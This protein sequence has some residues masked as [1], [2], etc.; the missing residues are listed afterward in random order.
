L[1]LPQRPFAF[2]FQPSITTILH[3]TVLKYNNESQNAKAK[4][5]SSSESNR[6]IVKD[7]YK[8][9]EITFQI[10]YRDLWKEDK[11]TFLAVLATDFD[12]NFDQSELADF[13]F[14]LSIHH[15]P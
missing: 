15:H 5:L 8:R 12:L 6:A 11:C 14:H 1:R 4:A 10:L 13:S 3:K 9:L 7:N 2:K